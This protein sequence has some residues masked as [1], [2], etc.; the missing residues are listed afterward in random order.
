[1]MASRQHPLFSPV[2]CLAALVIVVGAGI[3]IWFTGG[4]VFNP[5]LLTAR[6]V[7]GA[8]LGGFASHAEFEN[9]CGKCHAPFRGVEAGRC[10]GCH[11][12]VAE[13]RK[14][15]VGLHGGLN[16]ETVLQCASCHQ[17][18]KGRD[19]NPS[20][21]P[22][23]NFD[24]SVVRFALATHQKTYEGSSFACQ[25]CHPGEGYSFSQQTCADCHGRADAG[26]I[27]EHVQSFGKDCLSCHD[28]TGNIKNFDH[29]KFF[30]LEGAHAA[31]ECT[32]CH[33]NRQFKGT[34]TECLAC[35]AEPDVHKGL[36]GTD[37]A[38]CHNTTAWKPAELPNHTFPLDHG[39][40]GVQACATCHPATF[41]AYTCYACH[42]HQPAE[43]AARHA[44]EGIGGERLT[45]CAECH[46][47][48]RLE[49]GGGDESGGD[50]GGG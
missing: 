13:E 33:V 9:D 40:R 17:D 43:I 4:A 8:A 24:H 39:G 32:A 49:G 25:T 42:E 1:M 6:T 15:G 30:P 23:A 35:H 29:R 26:F 10:E 36:F 27:A 44:E 28:G 12:T 22:L 11:V 48:G 31:V 2:G 45:R 7:A 14:S 16:L 21:V 47:N 19:F 50:Q 18:H 5:G 38:A 3:A 20:V 34:A 46:S 41:S 37:C